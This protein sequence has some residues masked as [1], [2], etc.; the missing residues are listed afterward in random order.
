ML[1]ATRS[2]QFRSSTRAIKPR[3]PTAGLAWPLSPF[4]R[5]RSGRQQART[6][7]RVNSSRFDGSRYVKQGLARTLPPHLPTQGFEIIGR[8][9]AWPSRLRNWDLM[10]S[11]LCAHAVPKTSGWDCDVQF[12]IAFW[13]QSQTYI[14]NWLFICPFLFFF[15]VAPASVKMV[16]YYES[17]YIRVYVHTYAKKP[18]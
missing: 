17:I 3:T 1:S 9:S 6:L 14:T 10:S 2:G 4:A 13:K 15:R 11:L 8:P 18:R 12:L 16:R 7:P 5:Q